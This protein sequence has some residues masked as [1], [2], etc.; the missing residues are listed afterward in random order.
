MLTDLERQYLPYFAGG[1]ANKEIANRFDVSLSRVKNVKE[2]A[3]LHYGVHNAAELS[4]AWICEQECIARERYQL[5][6]FRGALL[7]LAIVIYANLSTLGG[8]S[9]V[10]RASPA[11]GRRKSESEIVIDDC[12]EERVEK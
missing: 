12:E 8:Y 1:A 3:Y 6:R 2:L 11:R 4:C 10:V 5:R 9:G 7:S